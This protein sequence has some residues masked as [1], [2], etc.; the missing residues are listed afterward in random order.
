M[1]EF[2]VISFQVRCLS[3]LNGVQCKAAFDVRY[4]NASQNIM[5]IF[6]K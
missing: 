6:P 2:K 1:R 4:N 3:L 5:G